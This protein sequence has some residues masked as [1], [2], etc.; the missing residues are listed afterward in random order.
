LGEAAGEGFAG[1]L[2]AGAT[3]GIGFELITGDGTVAAPGAMVGVGEGW[4]TLISST[5][6]IKV[7]FGPIVCPAPRSP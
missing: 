3:D 7:A 4:A 6:K 5:S 1:A 2:A